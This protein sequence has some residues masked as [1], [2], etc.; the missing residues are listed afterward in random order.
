V[1]ADDPRGLNPWL[2]L[3]AVAAAVVVAALLLKLLPPIIVL[4]AFVGGI[5]YVNARLKPISGKTKPSVAEARVLGLERSPTDRF[6][7]LG[8]PLSLF[9]RERDGE[10]IDVLWGSWR[11]LDVKVFE[12]RSAASENDAAT[13]RRFACALGPAPAEFPA[14]SVEPKA[15]LTPAAQRGPLRAMQLGEG[16]FDDRFD[17]RCDDEVFARQLLDLALRG[18]MLASA[19]SW[20]FEV[21]GRLVLTYR[22]VEGPITTMEALEAL[23]GFLERIPKS[24]QRR[25]QM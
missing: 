24:A 23:G 21:N 17:L 25:V 4:A 5:A 18:W 8:Y 3:L 19:D 15:F 11:R 1:G 12:Y 22:L 2:R 16:M 9:T 14:L 6:G 7:L 10:L 13:P 20:G